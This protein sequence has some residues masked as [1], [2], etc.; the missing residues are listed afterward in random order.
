MTGALRSAAE[1]TR[2]RIRFPAQ[3]RRVFEGMSLLVPRTEEGIWSLRRQGIS[4]MEKTV[5][6]YFSRQASKRWMMAAAWARVAVP[7]GWR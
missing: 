5:L 1:A 6:R 7:C 4:L 3:S 2:R